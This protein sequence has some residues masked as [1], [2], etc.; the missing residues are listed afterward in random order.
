MALGTKSRTVSRA[1]SARS[2]ASAGRDR[3][4]ASARAIASN[5]LTMCAARSLACAMCCSE[6][7]SAFGSCSPASISR[8]ASSAC[9][10]SPASGVFSWCA[11][12]AR[13]CFCELIESSSRP[14]RSLIALTS[15][16]TSS[17]TSRS[18][19]GLRSWLSRRRMRCCSSFSG[20]M[21]R[22]SANHTSSTASGSTTN[23]GTI[24]PLMI[25]VA[26][27]WRRSIVSATCTSGA[28]SPGTPVGGSHR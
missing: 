11:A 17:G 18:A 15:G 22:A 7:F 9:M 5:W 12:S 28:P 2:T 1:N 19:N 27:R 14:S 21:P 3:C 6:R 25:S 13:K 8:C 26:R 20:L 16:A 10:R 4:L 24:T 23:C